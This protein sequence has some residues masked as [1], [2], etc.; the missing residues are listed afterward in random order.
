[1]KERYFIAVVLPQDIRAEVGN[2]KK[3]ISEKYHAHHAFKSPAH[4]TLHM[5]FK[6][7]STKEEELYQ[8]LIEITKGMKSFELALQNFGVFEPRVI[9]V[10][11]AENK[12]LRVLRDK[13]LV[14][15]GKRQVYNGEYKNSGFQP[16]I[17]I[18]FRDLKKANFY[19]AWETFKNQK[20]ERK[21]SVSGITLL[22]HQSGH[23]DEMR[24]FQF[25]GTN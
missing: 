16:H 9:F 12:F 5:P 1:V 18:A 2:F 13:V 4:I 17:T 14:E 22:K 19:E 10:D 11:V 15:M 7:E 6:W 24:T 20:Y 25:M 23:W 21:F 8:S 3:I